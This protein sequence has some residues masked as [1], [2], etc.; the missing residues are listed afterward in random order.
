MTKRAPAPHNDAVP[1][2]KKR[3]A[4]KP[5]GPFDALLPDMWG[6]I[7]GHLSVVDQARRLALVSRTCHDATIPFKGETIALSTKEWRHLTDHPRVLHA[8][9]ADHA[10]TTVGAISFVD[11]IFAEQGGVPLLTWL[12]DHQRHLRDLTITDEEEDWWDDLS[13]SQSSAFMAVV[14]R[15]DRLGISSL[16]F[17]HVFDHKGAVISPTLRELVM[18]GDLPVRV[19]TRFPGIEKLTVR[20]TD[21]FDFAGVAGFAALKYLDVSHLS[22]VDICCKPLEQLET[23]VVR[24]RATGM[25]N[26][27]FLRNTLLEMLPRL[28]TLAW[29]VTNHWQLTRTAGGPIQGTLIFE[30]DELAPSKATPP[31]DSSSDSDSDPVHSP[32]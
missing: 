3:R 18:V 30:E 20:G 14:A 23:L 13:A 17:L 2:S 26:P 32:Q 21:A 24:H 7:A 9:F 6:E 5:A 27:T 29:I 10:Y 16:A 31:H 25:L 11:I 8:R 19:S 12:H 15:L 1:A 22:A 4:S 28:Q